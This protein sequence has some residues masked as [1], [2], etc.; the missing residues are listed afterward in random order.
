MY[1]SYIN[2]YKYKINNINIYIIYIIYKICL[3]IKYMYDKS[4][5]L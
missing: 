4:Y 5:F 1:I 2:I 3:C